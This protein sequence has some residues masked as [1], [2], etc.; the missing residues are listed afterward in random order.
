M[1]YLKK[2]EAIDKEENKMIIF[3]KDI[4]KLFEE[5]YTTELRLFDSYE[6]IYIRNE[7]GFMTEIISKIIM[8]KEEFFIEIYNKDFEINSLLPEYFK[9]VKGMEF[10]KFYINNSYNF[11][12]DIFD[13]EEL[14]NN[15]NPDDF[16]V[17]FESNKYNL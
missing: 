13:K 10:D 17:F 1:K 14:L 2:F 6:N 8:D 16:K 15:L 9:T 11:Q 5:N 7:T 3:L 12:Y 4:F